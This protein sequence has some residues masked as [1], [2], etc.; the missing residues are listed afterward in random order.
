MTEQQEG[1]REVDENDSAFGEEVYSDDDTIRSSVFEYPEEHGRTYHAYKD[2]TFFFP[3]DEQ[4]QARLDFQHQLYL[5]LG[6]G[7]LYCS[8]VQN[9]SEILDLGTGTGIWAMEV[10][11]Q[12]PSARVLGI[13]LSPIQ[14]EWVPNNC[15]FQIWDFEDGWEFERRFD[16]IHGRFLIGSISAPE[17]LIRRAYEHLVPG[18]WLEL[19]DVC[20]PTS[21]DN[22]IPSKSAYRVWI[23]TWCE[24]LRKAGRDPDLTTRYEDLMQKAGFINVKVE[25]YKAPQNIWPKHPHYKNLGFWNAKNI[26]EGIE[27]LSMRPFTKFL[28]WSADE[29]QAHLA[30]TRSDIKN[31]KI[32]AYW[33]V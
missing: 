18:G 7:V 32:H 14:P 23:D 12:V 29:V 8:P 13:D 28:Q 3:N 24:A 16:L 11:E 9:P 4:E 26:L 21:D 25:L 17:Q 27:G 22:T 15:N 10:A 2:G 5:R 30:K 19:Q 33:P 6:K 20:P 31:P 1:P